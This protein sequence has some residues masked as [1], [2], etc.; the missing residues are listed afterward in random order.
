M[1]LYLHNFLQDKTDGKIFY[2]L[3]IIPAK[4]EEIPGDYNQ[5]MM[6][7]F[8]KRIDFIALG[9]AC[10][11]LGF[12]FEVPEDLEHFEEQQLKHL[13][14]LLFEVEVVEGEL[15]S[16]SGKHFPII[17]GIPDMSPQIGAAPPEAECDEQEEDEE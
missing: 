16:P 12:D 9:S 17:S 1:K 8:V 5:D 10:H 6:E 7:R 2:P 3:Q 4:V 13:H 11:D 14:H 15:V